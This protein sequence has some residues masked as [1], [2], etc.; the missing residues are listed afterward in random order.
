M[1]LGGEW[2]GRGGEGL[3]E[4]TTRR[5]QKKKKKKEWK[6][7]CHRAEVFEGFWK[8]RAS[9]VGLRENRH[10]LIRCS[11]TRYKTIR[12]YSLWRKM[13]QLGTTPTQM[14]GK[15]VVNVIWHFYHC[16]DYRKGGE[17]KRVIIQLCFPL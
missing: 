15:T 12:G 7:G 1:V 14:Q 2:E 9:R 13:T 8:K 16:P 3:Q 17:A 10:H 11:E 4:K 6:R 5:K